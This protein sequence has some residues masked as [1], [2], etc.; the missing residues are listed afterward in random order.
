MNIPTSTGPSM[1]SITIHVP[2]IPK[3]GGSKTSTLIRRKGGTI[4][5]HNGR[6]LIT[7]RDACKGN[8][9]WK[10]QVAFFARQVYSGDPLTVP[11]RAMV[12]FTMPRPKWH[13]R[14][15]KNAGVLKATAPTYHTSKPDATKLW[16]STE[17]ALVGIVFKDDSLIAE[18]SIV[19]LYG[20]KT[21]ARVE[22][23]PLVENRGRAGA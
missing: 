22:I 11:L 19:K 10:Q 3:P 13:Y 12:T 7:T 8:A 20:E 17:D 4:V 16:R 23:E 2:G 21:G 1:Q 18:Q 9:Q 14:T 5:M 6:P 15:G